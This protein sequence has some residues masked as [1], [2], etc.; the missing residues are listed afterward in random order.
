MGSAR[1]SPL[2]RHWTRSPFPSPCERRTNV[3]SRG[4]IVGCVSFSV[5]QG[6]PVLGNQTVD[7]P[8][9]GLS[10]TAGCGGVSA[11][12]GFQGPTVV[13]G[14]QGASV[15][16][17]FHAASVTTGR[18]GASA[19]TG[20]QGASVTGGGSLLGVVHTGC[21]RLGVQPPAE[22][23]GGRFPINRRLTSD[24][25]GYGPWP[26]YFPVKSSRSMDHRKPPPSPRWRM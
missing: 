25:K 8:H 3:V 22:A 13:V 9:T 23:V 21:S 15:T 4:C 16:T 14:G 18:Q 20:R 17:G 11:G 2:I 5:R 19:V 1:Y 24:T 26:Q 7:L 6:L 10:V 12:T